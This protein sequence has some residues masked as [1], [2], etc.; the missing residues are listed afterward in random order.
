M[1]LAPFTLPEANMA[2]RDRAAMAQSI[3]T[4]KSRADGQQCA[5]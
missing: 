2:G 1:V 3:R 4:E 5:A